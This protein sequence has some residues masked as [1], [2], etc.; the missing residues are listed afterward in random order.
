MKQYHNILFIL[1]LTLLLFPKN[2]IAGKCTGSAN[3]RACTS[4]S[5]C[6]HCNRDDGTCGVCNGG[7][8]D[9]YSSSNSNTKRTQWLPWVIVAALSGYIIK[10]ITGNNNKPKE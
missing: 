6:K 8:N 2:G 1:L 9:N 7:G 5:S 3:C 10:G 4:C